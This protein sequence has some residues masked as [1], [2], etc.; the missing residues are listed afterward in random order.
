MLAL[1]NVSKSDS[2]GELL[3]VNGG[4]VYMKDKDQIFHFDGAYHL[5]FKISLNDEKFFVSPKNVKLKLGK[6]QQGNIKVMVNPCSTA[7]THLP[8]SFSTKNNIIFVNFRGK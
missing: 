8:A 2:Y 5:L 7:H 3:S 4:A 6:R 1:V